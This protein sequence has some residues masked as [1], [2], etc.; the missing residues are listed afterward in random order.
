[1]IVYN[2][3]VLGIPEEMLDNAQELTVDQT[4]VLLEAMAVHMPTSSAWLN[5]VSYV[6][7]VLASICCRG[8]LIEDHR[9]KIMNGVKGEM[10]GIAIY[11]PELTMKKFYTKYGSKVNALNARA[12]MEHLGSLVP[13]NIIAKKNWLS[14]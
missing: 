1:M 13:E 5:G 14:S 4:L 6:T 9:D 2:A 3:E 7:T 8:T 12:T 10:T 11:I